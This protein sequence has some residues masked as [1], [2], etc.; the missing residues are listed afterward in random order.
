LPLCLIKHHTIRQERRYS[1]TILD[2]CT[3]WRWV[4]SFMPLPLYPWG[5]H[6]HYPLDRSLG[7]PKSQFWHYGEKETLTPHGN[8][9]SA[10]QPAPCSYTN[11]D[12][13]TPFRKG[14][15]LHQW[16][17]WLK[18]AKHYNKLYIMLTCWES[19]LYD[20]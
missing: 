19:L 11:Q 13:L 14:G 8:W 2:L 20:N 10:A 4:L 7:G 16:P 18:S 15:K 1:S 3:R 5:N 12:I 6:P 9:T 17:G